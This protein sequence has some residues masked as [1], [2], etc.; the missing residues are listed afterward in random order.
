[1]MTGHPARRAALHFLLILAACA[2]NRAELSIARVSRGLYLRGGSDIS[3][4]D[5]VEALDFEAALR[6]ARASRQAGQSPDKALDNVD[7]VFAGEVPFA[8]LSLPLQGGSI[9]QGWLGKM[10][11][12]LLLH[13]AVKMS[14]WEVRADGRSLLLSEPLPAWVSELAARSGLSKP[15]GGL[16][17]EECELHALEKGQSVPARKLANSGEEATVACISLVG[18]GLLGLRKDGTGVEDCTVTTVHLDAGS[19]ILLRD[20][21]VR[22]L[23]VGVGADERHICLIMRRRLK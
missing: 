21:A 4:A 9:A 10:E 7:L 23:C 16:G 6:A 20:E 8:P 22:G 17:P 11:G 14:G 1:M 5:D 19:C 15:F 12:R 2:S 18:R 3:G 13:E